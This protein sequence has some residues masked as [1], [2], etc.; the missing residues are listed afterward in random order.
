MSFRVYR[1]VAWE[2]IWMRLAALVAIVLGVPCA[3][4]CLADCISRDRF[5]GRS[6]DGVYRLDMKR[7]SQERYEFSLRR[8]DT[9]ASTG[10]ID[11]HG[12][13]MHAM[14]NDTGSYFV[15]YDVYEGI[16]VYDSQ[17]RRIGNLTVD[18]LLTLRERATRPGSWG[19]HP[20]GLWA[21]EFR[22]L[23]FVQGG[24]TIEA[25][26]H[27][28]RRITIDLPTARIVRSETDVLQISYIG[29][30]AITAI[31]ATSIVVGFYRRGK[32]RRDA[33]NDTPSELS[34]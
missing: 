10:V 15:F 30:G 29:G 20:E 19:C 8:N 5:E 32:P 17:G 23:S 34:T 16:A 1:R 28:G 6:A 11:L 13:H 7:V 22:P 3:D 33:T 25:I 21:K 14:I 12:H 9:I 26:T 31:I 27:A 2:T 18:E 24:T 4:A